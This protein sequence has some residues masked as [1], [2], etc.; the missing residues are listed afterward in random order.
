MNSLRS[1]AA[2]AA[3][4]AAALKRVLES[5]HTL[6]FPARRLAVNGSLGSGHRAR[7]RGPRGEG[8]SV[9]L[10]VGT[11][12]FVAQGATTVTTGSPSAAGTRRSEPRISLRHPINAA[13]L[14]DLRTVRGVEE[15][16]PNTVRVSGVSPKTDVTHWP[17]HGSAPAASNFPQC[18][19]HRCV[20]LRWRPSTTRS[21]LSGHVE[22]RRPRTESCNVHR[23]WDGHSAS[24]RCESGMGLVRQHL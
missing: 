9:T 3:R 8:R 13:D 16:H 15:F 2:A 4:A 5:D 6:L 14:R 10:Q 18:L 21:W 20:S 1:S 19:F 23:S 11:Y 17:G 22:V 7:V 12:P 24:V